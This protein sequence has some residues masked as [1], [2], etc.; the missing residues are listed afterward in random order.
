MVSHNSTR[1]RVSTRGCL[2]SAVKHPTDLLSKWGRWVNAYHLL[3]VSP[4]PY[5]VL[6]HR[7]RLAW[8]G[9]WVGFPI[10]P[11]K[12]ALKSCTPGI[13][14]MAA[15][16]FSA[17]GNKP[18][19]H[20]ESVLIQFLRPNEKS[21]ASF[22]PNRTGGKSPVC[23]TKKYNIPML[24]AICHMCPSL[25]CQVFL[26]SQTCFIRLKTCPKGSDTGHDSTS[27]KLG[28]QEGQIRSMR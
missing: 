13:K 15:R 18:L 21:R 24:L 20:T 3:H 14:G 16:H 12:P 1:T 25:L 22:S 6:H 11:A 4:V 19:G 8:I 7:L 17:L 10:P 9:D 28:K 5:W 26:V 23:D 2:T 27:T